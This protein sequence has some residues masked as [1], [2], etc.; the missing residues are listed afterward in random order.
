MFV[1]PLRK[2]ALDF[3][4]DLSSIKCFCRIGNDPM[5]YPCVVDTGAAVTAVPQQFWS[6]QIQRSEIESSPGKK[7]GGVFGAAC[8]AR[9]VSLRMEI[10]NYQHE[11]FELGA[12]QV[13]LLFDRDAFD[14]AQAVRRAAALSGVEGQ[15]PATPL[16][17]QLGHILLGLGGGVFKMGGLCI[18]WSK[19]DVH[20]VDQLL[21]PG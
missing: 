4:A 5:R 10:V 16:P 6:R 21:A 2:M 20:L 9:L 18:N 1:E 11:T 17:R 7:Y 13:A 19:P 3:D 15:K 12:C 14:T 8:R